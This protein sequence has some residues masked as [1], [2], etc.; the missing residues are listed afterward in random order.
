MRSIVGVFPSVEAGSRAVERAMPVVGKNC[1]TL[2]LPGE[3]HVAAK[4]PATE[5]M[6]PVGAPIAGTLAGLLGAGVALMIPGVGAITAFGAAAAAAFGAAA[7]YAGWKIGE[8]ADLRSYPGPSVDELYLYEDALQQG[9]AVAI[10]L[11]RDEDV[12][13]KLE[14]IFRDAGAESIDA[15]RERWW[16]GIRDAEAEQYAI[17]GG[18]FSADERPFREGFESAL[19]AGPGG[20][21]FEERRS[22]LAAGGAAVE[23]PAFRR[24]FERGAA[25]L[26][27]R[28]RSPAGAC[29]P[30]AEREPATVDVDEASRESFP[31]SDPP[32][33]GGGR[34]GTPV[35]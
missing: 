35:R 33:V 6:A 24:G 2:L 18:D 13:E 7:G 17:D 9:R 4:V 20:G 30:R 11:A 8:T 14:A 5:D 28:T 22:E 10:G 1:V 3:S 15:A 26:D 27:R 25:F 19:R 29:P 34:T 23:H 32:A 31:A 12:Y 21:S 16:L